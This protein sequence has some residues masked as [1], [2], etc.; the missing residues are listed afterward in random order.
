RVGRG[1]RWWG[2][3]RRPTATG[4]VRGATPIDLATPRRQRHRSVRD[5]GRGRT[6]PQTARRVLMQAIGTLANALNKFS[7]QVRSD[8]VHIDRMPPGRTIRY[9][10]DAFFGLHHTGDVGRAHLDRVPTRPRVPGVLPLAPGVGGRD[11]G[12]L[13]R[14]PLTAVEPD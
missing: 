7:T 12:E 6:L 1:D 11:C 5:R 14:M 3:R 4:V 10:W 9:R 2:A 13:G 8:H